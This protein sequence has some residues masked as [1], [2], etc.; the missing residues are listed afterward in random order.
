MA[1]NSSSTGGG[2]GIGSVIAVIL[3]WGVN[4]SIGW[5]IL[6]GIFGW[7]YVIYYALGYGR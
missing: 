1:D 6:H 4:H 5:A 2:I 7:F 3:S